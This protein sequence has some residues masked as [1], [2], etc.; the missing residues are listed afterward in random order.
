M[1]N[2][3]QPFRHH[4]IVKA[5]RAAEAA[6]VRNPSVEVR[7]PNGTVFTIGSKPDEVISAP[8]PNKPSVRRRDRGRK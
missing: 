7:I 1:A 8:L 3:P 5:F 6:G 4:H 2:Q